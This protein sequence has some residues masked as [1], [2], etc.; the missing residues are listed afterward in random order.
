MEA[1]VVAD[2]AGHFHCCLHVERL[3]YAHAGNRLPT[4][5]LACLMVIMLA[6]GCLYHLESHDELRV[7]QLCVAD[8]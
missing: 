1:V 4:G 7:W 5:L 8:A 2:E 6:D 3:T